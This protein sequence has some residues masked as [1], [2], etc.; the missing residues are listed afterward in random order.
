MKESTN[1]LR[2]KQKKRLRKIFLRTI[3]TTLTVIA[4]AIGGFAFVYNKF[5]YD[6]NG[7]LG[8]KDPDPINKTVAVFG[9]DEDGYRTDVIF[10]VNFNSESGKTRIL[11]IPR[12]TRV[13]WSE[14]QRELMDEV[15]GY[16]VSVSKINE[17][18]SYVGIDKITEFTI[19]EIEELTGI[20]VDNYVVV[21]IDAFKKIVDAV[22]GVEVDVPVLNGNGL[23]YDDNAQDLHIHLSPGLQVL[24]GEAAEG[25][26]RF[27]KGYVEGDVGRIKTQQ[28]FLEGFAKKVTSPQIITKLPAI[29][30]TVMQNVTTDVSLSEALGYIPYLKTMNTSQLKA[31][32]IPGEGRYQGG[33][34]YFFPDEVQMPMF[35]NDFLYGSDEEEGTDTEETV[36]DQAVSIEVLNSTGTGGLA[37]RAKERLEN[38][39]YSVNSIGNYTEDTLSTTTIYTRERRLAKQFLSY[40]P[41][42]NIIES[43]NIPYDI[44]II[45]GNDSAQ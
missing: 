26:V 33:K 7:I 24:D 23:Q 34:S 1:K 15:K 17:M 21:T 8:Q 42:A 12:D 39:G 41:N 45:L 11:S 31:D 19:P 14:H 5:I 40:Y 32:I 22:G 35:I 4:I 38:E 20:H 18:T 13:E 28:L 10:I 9:V 2:K 30:T 43:S 6:G 16:S 27:R 36:I 37:G 25:L 29:A 3:L 44:Q